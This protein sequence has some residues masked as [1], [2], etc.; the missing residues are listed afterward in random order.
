M[1]QAK[2]EGHRLQDELFRWAVAILNEDSDDSCAHGLESLKQEVG[3]LI[4]DGWALRMSAN[5]SPADKAGVDFIWENPKRGWFPL[6]AKAMGEPSCRLIS[7]VRVGNNKDAGEQRQLSGKYKSAFLAQLI[8]LARS[9]TPV[10]HE[11]CLPPS[12]TPMA[13]ATLLDA[14]KQLRY[15]LEKASESD[16]RLGEWAVALNRAI[17]YLNITK[18]GPD[19]AAISAAQV[20]V[21]S[22]VDR[23]LEAYF[24]ENNTAFVSRCMHLQPNLR[25]SA[26]LHYLVTGDIIKATVGEAK[27]VVVLSG[28]KELISNR[29]QEIY[30][31]LVRKHRSSDWLM[32]RKRSFASKGIQCAIHSVLDAFQQSAA[33]RK[34]R[35]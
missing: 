10:R 35:V 27:E 23:F 17:A 4:K 33:N 24:A 7:H 20:L 1:T 2:T 3:I 31:E 21:A 15:Q 22:A 25:R 6:D 14:L 32:Q 26:Q 8:Q 16:E 12:V 13:N 5:N 18:R 29:F 11:C 28:L 34:P 9:G 30:A 19:K